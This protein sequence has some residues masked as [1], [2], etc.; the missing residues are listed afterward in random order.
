M[1]AIPSRKNIIDIGPSSVVYTDER[2]K[3]YHFPKGP[4]AFSKK[5]PMGW[6]RA[7]R[8]IATERDLLNLH[9]TFYELPANN[10]GGITKVR[11]VS[12]HNLRGV[13]DFCSYRGLLVLSGITDHLNVKSKH[14]IRS[15]DNKVALWV[16]AVDDLWELGKP[17][18]KGGP[19]HKT[20][21]NPNSPSD[22]Y[23]MTGYDEKTL[24][25]KA[26]SPTTIKIEVDI[27]GHNDWVTYKTAKFTEAEKEWTHKFP[28]GFNA[29]WIRFRSTQPS[30]VT[31]ELVYR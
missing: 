24:T 22:P 3:R 29:Y 20:S 11:P 2:K 9:G 31:T 28:E 23:L 6:G 7:V 14:I 26:S 30:V 17:V 4:D 8:E 16:G 13:H 18:G 27:S 1:A 15:K 19:W 10:A 21:V 5:N 25:I 12:S